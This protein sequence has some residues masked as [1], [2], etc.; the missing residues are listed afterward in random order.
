MENWKKYQDLFLG[1]RE[2]KE[3]RYRQRLRDTEYKKEKKK[4]ERRIYRQKSDKGKLRE[5]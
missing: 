2:E 3:Y 5:S 4:I 1:N